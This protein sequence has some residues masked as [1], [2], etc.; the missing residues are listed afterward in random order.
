MFSV[1]MPI[2]SDVITAS[3]PVQKEGI[4]IIV[5][6]TRRTDCKAFYDRLTATGEPAYGISVS[7]NKISV[8]G[9]SNYLTYL[10][11]DYLLN[12][13]IT[14]D[15]NGS[16]VLTLKDG[17]EWIETSVSPYPDPVELLRSGKQCAFYSLNKIAT[18][19]EPETYSTMQGGGSDGKY[20]YY[21]FISGST[22]IIRKYDM[23]T[24]ALVATSE[25]MPS[26]HSNDITYDEKNHRLV[27]SYCSAA[28]GY[29]SVVTVN[30]DTLEY[31]EHIKTPTVNCG[32]AYLPE[33]DEYIFAFHD[34]YITD[35][36]F[37]TVRKIEDGFPKLT[38]QGCDSD[39]TLIYDARWGTLNGIH[40]HVS[41]HSLS[42]SFIGFLPIYGVQGDPENITCDGNTFI[43]GCI[44]PTALYRLTL[45]PVTW[46]E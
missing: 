45:L 44:G 18:L 15:A 1:T 25:P 26:G 27:V 13:L 37:R 38:T 3:K 41:V 9:T 43:L 19:P 11:L 35:A 40:Q 24:W 5:G 30:P 8:T 34:Y 12:N 29:L 4:E 31:I 23:A 33:T 6:Q 2:R 39:G 17:F 20:A 22:G 28:D 16:P 36:Q 7:G 42:G 21:A 46:W 10:A 32:L 14:Q